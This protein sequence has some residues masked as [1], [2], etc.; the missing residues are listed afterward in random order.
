MYKILSRHCL[1]RSGFHTRDSLPDQQAILIQSVRISS[2]TA[3]QNII[4]LYCKSSEYIISVFI[5]TSI[6]FKRILFITRH[7]KG[8]G[9]EKSYVLLCFPYKSICN[10]SVCIFQEQSNSQACLVF[11]DA[12]MQ[13]HPTRK[14]Y[15]PLVMLRICDLSLSVYA[16]SLYLKTRIP[17]RA[18]R[19][20]W[21]S[22]QGHERLSLSMDFTIRTKLDSCHTCMSGYCSVH[23]WF[24][25]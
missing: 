11:L 19:Q 21:M 3:R 12:L 17:M 8:S 7:D 24:N 6:W 4:L 18:L 20:S 22:F 9:R 16:N 2:E 10:C 14:N 25:S 1:H 23:R 15:A 13:A 5:H